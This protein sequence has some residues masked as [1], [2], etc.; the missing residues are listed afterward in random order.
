[1]I[2]V[3]EWVGKFKKG[4]DVRGEST[5]VGEIGGVFVFFVYRTWLLE[6]KIGILNLFELNHFS[7]NEAS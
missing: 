2:G 4:R 1:M 3:L 5:S 7:V 6:L